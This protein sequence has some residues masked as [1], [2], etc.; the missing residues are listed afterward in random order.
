MST[1]HSEPS[2]PVA[3]LYFDG[4]SAR[5]H[6]VTLTLDG[7]TLH[8]SGADVSRSDALER[9]RLS[10]PMGQAARLISYADGAHAEVRDHAAL[11]RLLQE[12]G[13]RD[14][15]F[16]RWA[17]DP[18]MVFAMFAGLLL[19]GWF[20]WQ[21]GLP[22]AARMAA[23]RVPDEVV[24]AMS[25]QA[26]GWLD[27]RVLTASTLSAQRQQTL[28]SAFDALAAG[29][30][31]AP[32]HSLQ[33]RHGGRMR[34]NAFALPDGTIIVTDELVDLAGSDDEVLAV[35]MHEL[36]H[37]QARHGIRMVLQGS[38][39]ALFMAWYLGDVSSLL[40]TAPTA[41]IQSGYSRS[42]E[43]EADDFAARE[44]VAQGRSPELL[45]SMLEKLARA[46]GESGDGDDGEGHLDWLSSH[47]D[48]GE[49][50]ARLRAREFAVH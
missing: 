23:P 49:R 27:N 20:A 3:A 7:A 35:L 29:E 11:A 4:L 38:A 31:S 21:V 19:A 34:A 40:A 12:S 25:T 17:F 26:L 30:G 13:H 41:L 14:H 18:R 32:R 9:V 15:A 1:S 22:W 28:R 47:P 6:A 46:H 2:R 16:V 48:T 37:V 44:L 5:A 43:S 45:V 33:F 36:G 50:I 10:E 8:L 39:T 42:M 24:S